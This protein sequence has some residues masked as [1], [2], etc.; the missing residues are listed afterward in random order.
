M[1]KRLQL[2]ATMRLAHIADITSGTD[3]DNTVLSAEEIF[4]F[5]FVG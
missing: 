3:S 4:C 5:P 1:K 2:V